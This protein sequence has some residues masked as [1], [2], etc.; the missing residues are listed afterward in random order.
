M[1]MMKK[2]LPLTATALLSL[3]AGAQILAITNHTTVVNDANIEDPINYPGRAVYYRCTNILFN[4]RPV[5]VKTVI[6]F[7]KNFISYVGT[8]EFY[9]LNQVGGFTISTGAAAAADGHFNEDNLDWWGLAPGEIPT[10]G[11]YAISQWVG[12]MDWNGNG[13]VGIYNEST[14]Y[15]EFETG[16][17]LDPGEGIEVTAIDS[18]PASGTGLLH[19]AAIRLWGY[20]DS[21]SDGI[22]DYFEVRYTGTTTVMNAASDYD[23]DGQSDRSEWITGH[24]PTNAAS[25]FRAT[26]E[27]QAGGLNLS[28]LTTT[29]RLYGVECAV[30]LATNTVWDGQPAA[31]N[32]PGTGATLSRF[33]PFTNLPMRIHRITAE[34]GPDER[35]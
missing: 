20:D 14:G 18:F 5:P 6:W 2:L 32:I 25:L 22:P 19:A 10:N 7:R 35:L 4:S 21:D 26:A 17:A 34:L 16:E 23:H 24:N 13:R 33:I 30:S 31:T 15:F 1:D 9:D 8:N 29:G 11:L 12:G 28:W 3:P 27:I